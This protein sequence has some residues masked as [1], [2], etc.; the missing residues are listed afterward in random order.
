MSNTEIVPGRLS[1]SGTEQSQIKKK[2]IHRN[3]EVIRLL[4]GWRP[5]YKTIADFRK[6]NLK[7]LKE[8]N[9]DFLQVCEELGLFGGEY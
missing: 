5:S 7:A 1:Q 3:L 6:D 4:R 9:K 8:V 2:E